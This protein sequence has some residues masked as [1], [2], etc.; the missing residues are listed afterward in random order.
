MKFGDNL[1]DPSYF[2]TL[3]S[4]CLCHVDIRQ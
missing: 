4:D 1:G 2:S 3:L